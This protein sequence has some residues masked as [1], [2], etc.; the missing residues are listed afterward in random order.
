MLLHAL[1]LLAFGLGHAVLIV[2]AVGTGSLTGA[3]SNNQI[4]V[5]VSANSGS[6]EGAGL[7]VQQAGQ[8]TL[9]LAVANNHIRQY[10]NEGILL[11]AGAGV[12]YGGNFNVSVSGNTLSNPGRN[13][14]IGNIFQGLALNNGVT[15]GD[16]F[17]TCLNV[18][19]NTL[20]GSGRNGGVDVRLRHR[21]NTTVLLP[22]Y[23]GGQYDAAAVDAYLL[24]RLGGS[25][26]RSSA[27]SGTGGG[28]QNTASNCT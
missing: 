4:G 17:T 3:F 5:A 18:G 19:T 26:T 10:N 8:G 11:Q 13:A 24:P 21:Q 6:L 25:P 14:A 20:T 28:F 23:G 12:T 15:P 27:S 1:L 22:G 2:V 16:T 9:T 7:K